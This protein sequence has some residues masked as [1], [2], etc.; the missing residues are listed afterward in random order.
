MDDGCMT[1]DKC[2]NEWWTDDIPWTNDKWIDIGWMTDEWMD[3]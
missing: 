1:D 2:V 3:R